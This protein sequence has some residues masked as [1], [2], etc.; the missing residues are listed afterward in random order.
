MGKINKN[1]IADLEILKFSKTG[2]GSAQL[3]NA[4]GN[5]S[6][7]EVPFTMPGE[8]ARC[9]LLRKR[10]G[11][12]ASLLEEV[13]QPSPDRIAPKCAHFAL[14]GGCR[15]QHVPY[16]RQLQEKETAV[17]ECFSAFLTPSVDFQPIAPCN[18]PWYYRNKMEFSFTSNAAKNHFLGLY[19]DSSRGKVFNLTECHLVK[20]WFS[21]AVKA[22]REW[23]QESSL[24]AYHPFSNTGSLRT[25]TVREGQRTGDRMV[26]LTVSGNP[27]YALKNY[28]LETLVAFLRAAI[29]PTDPGAFLS[30]FLRI[31]QIAKGKPTNFYEIHLHGPDH[32]REILQIDLNPGEKKHS[33]FFK[34]SPT[35]FFQPNTMQAEHLYSLALKHADIPFNSIVYDLYC[36]TG[37]LGICM[38]KHA[39]QV[40]GIEI[41]PESTLDAKCNAEANQC[42]NI[43]FLTGSVPTVLNQIHQ[44]KTY[45][46]PNVVVVDP[47]RAGL[48]RHSIEQ[49]LDLQPDTILYISCNPVSQADN[50][51]DLLTE[52]YLLKVVQPVDQFPQTPHIE[53]ILVLKRK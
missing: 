49:V 37:T 18:P 35:A 51:K 1:K 5:I 16:E 2:N 42:D 33:L 47:P 46:P 26:I 19:I 34:I 6:N 45:P 20:N 38:A 23:R 11:C 29:E 9:K 30:V 12:Y 43:T 39:K 28:H 8:I 21:E 17:R 36:G 52:N 40:I 15:W 22:V 41:A 50:L 3:Q 13:L 25:L 53:N 7:V 27:D 24:D 4:N 10:K 14:C 31:Q 48:D 32:I 44:E